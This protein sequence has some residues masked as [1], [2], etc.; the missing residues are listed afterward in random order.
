MNAATSEATIVPPMP[1]R[2]IAWWVAALGLVATLLVVAV[3]VWLDIIDA[4]NVDRADPVGMPETLL[5]PHELIMVP[6]ANVASVT[7]VAL[8]VFAI[9]NVKKLERGIR[10]ASVARGDT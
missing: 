7:V 2:A 8:L 5:L 9:I 10:K 3:T 4:I 6:I 1:G